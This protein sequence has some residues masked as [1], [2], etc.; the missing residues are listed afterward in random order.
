MGVAR[1]YKVGS[2]YNGVELNDLDFEQTADTMYLAHIDHAPTKLVRAGHTDWQFVTLT[3]GPTLAAP[4]SVNATATTPNTDS[5]NDGAAYFPQTDSYVVTAVNDDT[6]QESRASAEDSAV[7]DLSLKKNYNTVTWAAVTG[8]TRYNVYKA[9][10]SQFFGYIGTTEDLTFRD[11]NI[12]PALDRAPP[13]AFNPFAAPGDYP[14]TVTLFEQR[15]LYGRTKNAPNAVFG[16]RSGGSQFEN[17]DRSQPLR[18]DDSLSFAIVAGRVNAV[19]QLASTTTLLALTSDAIF[20]VDGDGNGGVLTATSQAPRRQ[21]GRGASRLPPLV[22]DNVVF[23]APSVGRSVRTIGFSFEIDGLKSDD[24]T[25]FSPDF[26]PKD[27][28]IVSWCYSQEPRSLIWAVRSDGKLLCFTWEQEQNVWGWTICETD[29]EVQ[30]VCSISEDGEDRV[31]LIVKRTIG[32]TDRFFVERMASHDWADLKECCFLDCAVTGVFEEA[33]STFTGLWHLEG[34]TD[35]A[36]LVDGV[37]VTGLTVENGSVTLPSDVPQGKYV[38]FG[39]PYEVHIETLPV[40]ANVPGQGWNVA[41]RQQA[42]E[43]ALTLHRTSGIYAGSS[44]SDTIY[45]KQRIGE[46][47]GTPDNLMTGDYSINSGNVEQGKVCVHVKQ[48]T[49]LPLTLL[50]AFVDPI[51]ND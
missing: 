12:A 45:V 4:G 7:N 27:M 34:R 21:I 15:L 1:V 43:I 38:T 47:W 17:F 44:A 16:S 29:G 30:S 31:Y 49:P 19:Q 11:D 46:A 40:R 22:V 24:I 23:Y 35:V 28:S 50:G 42:G 6:S 9:H 33:R 48:T 37:P 26:F 8:A 5:E 3:F 20:S 36:A 13:Q 32:E 51:I 39:L 10:N 41:R 2:P 14:S 18:A 25:I